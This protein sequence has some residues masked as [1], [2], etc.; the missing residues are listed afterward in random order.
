MPKY[1]PRL[2]I[3][4]KWEQPCPRWRIIEGSEEM[5]E[6]DRESGNI[7]RSQISLMQAHGLCP[8]TLGLGE[9]CVS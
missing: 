9:G 2:F 3:N 7:V 4:G 6:T 5:Q 1:S 8:S